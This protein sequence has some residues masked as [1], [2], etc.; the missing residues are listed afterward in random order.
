MTSAVHSFQAATVAARAAETET[1]DEVEVPPVKFKIEDEELGFSEE[2]EAR[3]PTDGELM[4]FMSAYGAN[5]NSI[6]GMAAMFELLRDVLGANGASRLRQLLKEGKITPPGIREIYAWLMEEWA[7]FPTQP[8]TKSSSSPA[9]TGTK[10][11][12]R[13]RA[14]ASTQPA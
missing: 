2:F 7:N 1:A 10:S 11:T 6:D 13:V 8:S 14:K 9:K 5:N 3:K 4:V 12:G